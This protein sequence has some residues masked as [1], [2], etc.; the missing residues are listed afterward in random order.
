MTNDPELMD[1]LEES[2]CLGNVIG[3]ESLDPR[4]LKSMKKASN[5]VGRGWDR[6]QA[7]CEILRSHH[8]QTWAAFT[9]GHDY[10]TV[11]TIKETLEFAMHHKFCFA[12]FNI[13]MP[14]PATPLYDRL[15][16]E[17]RLL[18]DGKWWLHPEYRFNHAA[19]QPK[20]MTPDE[21]TEACWYCRD[22]WN[23]TSSI[24]K[25]MWDFKT[26]MRS[27][28]RLGVYLTY[29]PI[30]AKEAYKKQGMLFGLFRDS[31]DTRNINP[32]RKQ[33]PYL[34][35]GVHPPADEVPLTSANQTVVLRRL[36]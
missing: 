5:L 12:A 25:R 8:L 33:R 26:H 16:R 21:L 30:Y 15:K 29:N 36:G 4:N 20:N 34:E 18:W 24:W 13:L 17:G 22:H 31:V 23:R 2:G 27:P 9:L 10:D 35:W 1:L 6:Y 3:F 11:K 32:L 19:F 28:T 7:Q 14:Y